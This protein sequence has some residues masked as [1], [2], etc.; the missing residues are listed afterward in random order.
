[1]PEQVAEA[2]KAAGVTLVLHTKPKKEDGG[3]QMDQLIAAAKA[4]G[5]VV[6]HLPKVGA[7]ALCAPSSSRHA[8]M[9]HAGLWR[10]RGC[11]GPMEDGG[12]AAGE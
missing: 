5:D 11:C 1:M 10:G 4:A 6:G 7:S 12:Q 3:E 2:A 9:R 8:H